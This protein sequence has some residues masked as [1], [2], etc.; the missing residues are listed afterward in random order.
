MGMFFFSLSQSQELQTRRRDRNR[1][2]MR[3][4]RALV[5]DGGPDSA[6]G[7]GETSPYPP[8]ETD[9]PPETDPPP[10]IEPPPETASSPPPPGLYGDTHYYNYGA[11]CEDPNSYPPSRFVSEHGF[12]SYP[13]YVVYEKVTAREDRYRSSPLL[14]KRQ[15]H[16][17]GDAQILA[18]IS[19]HFRVPAEIKPPALGGVG[20]ARKQAAHAA[21]AN[22]TLTAAEAAW[23]AYLYLS[24]AQQARCYE[25]AF[26][27]WRMSRSEP[28]VHTMGILY[29]QL[30]DIWPGP[31]WASVEY[32]GRTRLVHHAVARAFAPLML[33]VRAVQKRGKKSEGLEWEANV[34]HTRISPICH[35]S[36]FPCVRARACA[37]ARVWLLSLFLS[38]ISPIC[39]TVCFPVYQP[40]FFSS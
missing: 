1:I 24:Q 9:H 23:D 2:R 38:P 11:D 8:P 15:R 5:D 28:T 36:F 32:D 20:A 12:Q 4:R 18:M 22:G 29:W 31:S 33:S 7:N 30:N 37:R 6:D 34:S 25:T 26:T 14:K 19:R 39:H 40:T 16:P 35:T 13:A 17:E 21:G 10:E 27:Q 3:Q